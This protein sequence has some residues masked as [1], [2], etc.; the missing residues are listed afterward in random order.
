[1]LLLLEHL[2]RELR[3]DCKCLQGLSIMF[4][5]DVLRICRDYLFSV[6]CSQNN[7]VMIG[8]RLYLRQAEIVLGLYG[9]HMK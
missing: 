2:F 4:L 7:K 6:Q 3:S 8:L 9:I 5:G 1:M